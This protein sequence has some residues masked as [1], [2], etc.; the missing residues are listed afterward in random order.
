MRAAWL[1]VL[2]LAP[3]EA[4]AQDFGSGDPPGA[5]GALGLLE[6]A[7]PGEAGWALGSG[8][9]SWWAL[10]ELTTRAL[11]LQ[12]PVRAGRVALGLSQSGEEGIGWTAAGLA[13]GAVSEAGGGAVRAT[14]RRDRSLA[15]EAAGPW[16][17]G[18]G[19][20]VGAGAW[21]RPAAGTEVWV[22]APQ[23]MLR[24]IAPPLRRPLLL[25]AR[26]RSGDAALW[27][28]LSGPRRG[29]EAAARALGASL[30][31]GRAELWLEARDGPWRGSGGLSARVS[32]IQVSCAVET[33]PELDETV[34][35]SLAWTRL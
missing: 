26:V 5:R 7:L 33:H 30:T 15:S 25:G 21:I 8:W 11:A 29:G 24:G 2:L 6:D 4:L 3:A 13:I 17:V 16:G 28:T 22:S 20:E 27:G 10:P 32:A 1:L 34:R 31:A 23:L 35:L 12:A 19:G 18:R 9:T 14:F